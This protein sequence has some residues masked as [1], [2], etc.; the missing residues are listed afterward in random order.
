M[1][2]RGGG[3]KSESNKNEIHT[4]RSNS[5]SAVIPGERTCGWCGW[6]ERW[7][8]KDRKMRSKCMDCGTINYCDN[9]CR[10]NHREIHF[11]ICHMIIERKSR[12]TKLDKMFNTAITMMK[13]DKER[14]L[15]KLIKKHP[16]LLNRTT[17]KFNGKCLLH[18]A[19]ELNKVSILEMLL[20]PLHVN[21]NIKANN[22][23]TPLM[24]ACICGH[25]DCVAVLV[26]TQVRT[27][28]NVVTEDGYT[29]LHIAAQNSSASCIPLLINAGANV[30]AVTKSGHTALHVASEKN[31]KS[32]ISPLINGGANVNATTHSGLTALHV[33]SYYDTASCIP[34]LVDGGANVNALT[35]ENGYTPLH[36]ASANNNASL[37]FA[38]A[39]FA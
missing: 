16:D 19:C 9:K 13:E 7:T 31:S 39:I 27:N 34:L 38:S 4:N 1:S 15:Y 32:C 20:L 21:E 37:Y 6:S 3:G 17:Q 26:D 25:T 36:V 14:D 2:S 8:N 11:R 10:R 33:A 12:G 5:T 22:G 29:A 23:Q 35:S 24:S 30:N 28:V 18:A